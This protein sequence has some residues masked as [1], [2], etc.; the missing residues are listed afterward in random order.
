MLGLGLGLGFGL[1]YSKYMVYQP[2]HALLKKYSSNCYKV[3]FM[4]SCRL[5]GFEAQKETKF[6]KR[7]SAGNTS[8]LTASLSR[9]RSKIFELAMC[10]P[11]EYFVTLTLSSR[12]DRHDISAYKRSLSK[13]LNNLNYRNGC[14]IKYLL[15]PEQ[16]KDGSWHMHGLFMGIPS[17]FLVPFTLHDHLPYR[18]LNLIR[19]GREIF[20]WP[21]YAKKFGYVTCERIRDFVACAKYITKYITKE[22]EKNA[23]ALNSKLYLCSHGLKRAETICRGSLTKMFTPDFHNDYVAVKSFDNLEEAVSYFVD[24]NETVREPVE[25]F[26]LIQ[27]VLGGA[28]DCVPCLQ[29]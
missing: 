29:T 4:K 11:W 23:V 22:L 3:I 18:V 6:A 1:G 13:W 15:I 26:G 25:F 21:D 8:K 19:E 10:N 16:H 28:R 5:P 12:Y 20:N 9:T 27:R 24:D 14:N 17:S 2:N 7:N